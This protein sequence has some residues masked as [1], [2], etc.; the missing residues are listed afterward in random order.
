MTFPFLWV[1]SDTWSPWMI[2]LPK[3]LN[4]SARVLARWKDPP[5]HE[6]EVVGNRTP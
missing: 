3:D 4:R 1:I 2:S 5:F 6:G